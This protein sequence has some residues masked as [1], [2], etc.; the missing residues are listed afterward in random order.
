MKTEAIDTNS[1]LKRLLRVFIALYTPLLKFRL[2][3]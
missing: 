1:L 3:V 2:R